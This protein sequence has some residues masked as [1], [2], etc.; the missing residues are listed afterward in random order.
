[1][2][3]LFGHSAPIAAFLDR[4]EGGRF[5]HAWLFEGPVGVGK[6]HAAHMLASIVLGAEYS[7]TNGVLAVDPGDPIAHKINT[8][9]HPDFRQVNRVPDASGK[10]P[11]AISVDAIRG[12]NG[13]FELRAA[14]G[15]YRVAIVDSVDELNG[16]SA[17]ALLKTLEEPPE[18]CLLMLVHHGSASLLPTIR[19]RCVKLTFDR[20]SLADLRSCLPDG[21]PDQELLDLCEGS[22]GR[23]VEMSTLDGGNELLKTVDAFLSDWP[24]M[25]AHK[26]PTLMSKVTKSD[27]H[28]ELLMVFLS[29]RLSKMA[30]AAADS[31]SRGQYAEYWS[32]MLQARTNAKR[33]NL[34]ATEQAARLLGLMRELSNEMKA[35]V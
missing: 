30:Y 31:Y 4:M 7:H 18:K 34:D 24:N 2:D 28:L 9:A 20:L 23:L 16:N 29:K 3:Q 8:G 6:S 14:Q 35:N 12:M 17:N 25:P 26:I 21:E 13:F 19:S 33:L 11:Q 5:P 27:L 22:P 15:G 32:R 1:M 10:I